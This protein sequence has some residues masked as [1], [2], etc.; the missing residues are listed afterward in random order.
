MEKAEEQKKHTRKSYL[1]LA[2]RIEKSI[3]KFFDLFRGKKTAENQKPIVPKPAKGGGSSTG[4][5]H[6][7]PRTA[8]ETPPVRTGEPASGAPEGAE[9]S[10]TKERP[11]EDEKNEPVIGAEKLTPPPIQHQELT[12]RESLERRE[13]YIVEQLLDGLGYEKLTKP[14]HLRVALARYRKR[15]RVLARQYGIEETSLAYYQSVAEKVGRMLFELSFENLDVS[16]ATRIDNFFWAKRYVDSNRI[17]VE[18]TGNYTQKF[19]TGVKTSLENAMSGAIPNHAWYTLDANAYEFRKA[20][21]TLRK[22]G[23]RVEAYLKESFVSPRSKTLQSTWIRGAKNSLEIAADLAHVS[24]VTKVSAFLTEADSR[25]DGKIRTLPRDIY[26]FLNGFVPA[27]RIPFI[28]KAT[29]TTAARHY[30]MCGLIS[31]DE[32]EAIWK[33]SETKNATDSLPFMD[34]LRYWKERI[35]DTLQLR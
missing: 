28:S 22:Y 12:Q 29:F 24:F 26:F 31:Y 19:N 30:V 32:S 16:P 9:S 33:R 34:K 7:A 11:L 1:E 13:R 20:V 14:H 8:P 15:R 3:G 27:M 5:P 25:G 4:A 35:S 21:D 18:V 2:R 6:E 17:P 10:S 23:Y